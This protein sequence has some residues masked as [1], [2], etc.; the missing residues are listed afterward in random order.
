METKDTIAQIILQS[1][2]LESDVRLW[3]S[4]VARARRNYLNAL[5][6]ERNKRKGVKI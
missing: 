6:A 1:F 3:E 2:A 5:Q 4:N